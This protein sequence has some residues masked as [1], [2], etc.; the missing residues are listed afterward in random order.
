MIH[1]RMKWIMSILSKNYAK[2]FLKWAGGKGQL[3]ISSIVILFLFSC[4][5]YGNYKNFEVVYVY[6]GDTIMLN[7]GEKVRLIGID[8]PEEW[9][10]D[11]LSRDAQRSGQD[12]AVIK[13]MGKKAH[14]FTQNLV[15]NK[16]VRL[17][18]DLEKRDKYDRLL[19]YLYLSDGKFVN[20]AI[21]KEGYAYPLTIPP[22]V[23]HAEHFQA[24][25]QEARDNKR[26]LWK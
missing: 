3:I 4:D 10:S 13:A 24:L 23:R 14:D 1:E 6:D 25:Y 20:E 18:F 7:D 12:I 5:G 15:L 21:I 11:K 2:P 8:C 22:N 26:G 9:E 17:E 19:A 16:K